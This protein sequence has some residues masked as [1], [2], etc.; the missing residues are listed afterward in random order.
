MIINTLSAL[1]ARYVAHVLVR[2]MI[3]ADTAGA[4]V[5]VATNNVL[6]NSGTIA[7]SIRLASAKFADKAPDLQ[8]I[9]VLLENPASHIEARFPVTFLDPGFDHGRKSTN[10]RQI[11]TGK[12]VGVAPNKGAL[13]IEIAEHTLFVQC[14]NVKSLRQVIGA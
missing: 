10:G 4:G 1:H 8:A 3:P 2:N 7:N 9:A 11:A 5:S 14:A 13:L 6:S 12:V